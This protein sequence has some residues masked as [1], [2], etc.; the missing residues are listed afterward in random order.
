MFVGIV[1]ASARYIATGSLI[2]AP[3]FHATDGLAGATIAS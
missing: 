3:N 2:F 1:Q